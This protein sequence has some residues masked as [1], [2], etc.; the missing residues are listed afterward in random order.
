MKLAA[1]IPIDRRVARSEGRELAER[2]DGAVLFADLAGFTP[3]SEALAKR[4]G[5]LRGAEILSA[6]LNGLLDR[7]IAAV[8]DHH[9]S[10]VS[11]NGDAIT[12][13]FAAPYD[14]HALGCALAM[15]RDLE[16]QFESPPEL[17]APDLGLKTAV[18]AGPVRRFV[19]GDPAIQRMD[20][21]TG[22]LLDRMR[23]AEQLA[24]AG[25]VIVD[26]EHVARLGN[27]LRISAWREAD[28][29][30]FAVVD[31][32]DALPAPESWGP[33]EGSGV[34][35]RWDSWI[36]SQVR[37]RLLTGDARLFAEFRSPVVFFVRFDGIRYETDPDAG[38]QLDAFVRW[39]QGI[40]HAYEGMVLQL[41]VGD[42]GSYLYGAFGALLAHEDDN[43]RAATAAS[44]LAHPPAELGFVRD[45]GV[46][47]N[48][49]QVYAGA[50]G[51]DRRFTY[52]LLGREV[53]L[54][55]RFMQLA[56]ASEV[57]AT[58]PVHR[59]LARQFVFRARGEQAIKGFST[60]IPVHQLLERREEYEPVAS[61]MELTPLVGR[62][63]TLDV[64]AEG[65]DALQRGESRRVLVV[66]DAG[67]GKSRLAAELRRMAAG[68][69]MAAAFGQAEAIERATPYSAWPG[70]LRK[71]L[72]VQKGWSPEQVIAH[73]AEL[74][75]DT[76][77]D[78]LPLAGAALGIHLGDTDFT[79]QLEGRVRADN[80]RA[81]VV[82][83]V[84]AT[85]ERHGGGLLLAIEDL[86]WSNASSWALLALLARKVRPLLLVLT[87]RPVE[88]PPS[89]LDEL[90]DD[91]EATTIRLQALDQE[92]IAALVR[93]RLGV[94]NLPDE[95]AEF[96]AARGHGNPLFCEELALACLE[97]GLLEVDGG[98][99]RVPPGGMDRAAT[100]AGGSARSVV[101]A[102]IDRLPARQQAAL[103]A[104]SV[105]GSRFD[106]TALEA[107]ME[108]GRGGILGLLD[109]AEA[110]GILQRS[111]DDPERFAFHNVLFRDVVYESLLFAQRTELHEQAATWIEG[112]PGSDLRLLGPL[113]AHHWERAGNVPR[114]LDYLEDSGREALRESAS[115]ETVFLLGRALKLA[116]GEAD[117][118]AERLASWELLL[119][120]A[121][122]NLL[123]YKEGE[124]H[125]ERGLA[126]T[127][128][129]KPRSTTS[130]L[131]RIGLESAR[132]LVHR[133]WPRR[134][135][136]RLSGRRDALL[137]AARAYER[138]TE[139]Y[140]ITGRELPGFY[141]VFRQLNLSE[142]A[143]SSPELSRGYA[144]IGAGLGFVA[145][146]RMARFYF[147][148]AY[149][150]L[151][152]LDD[153]PSRCFSDILKGLYLVGVGRWEASRELLERA[154][155]IAQQ[156][157][158][159]RRLSDA[160]S[161]MAPLHLFT[162]RLADGEALGRELY[163]LNR[164]S[165][166]IR[167]RYEALYLHSLFLQEL[168]RDDEIAD[169]LER[170]QS[171]FGEHSSVLDIFLDLGIHALSSTH[172]VRSGRLDEGLRH[173]LKALEVGRRY[174]P[175]IVSSMPSFA[176]PGEVLL[177]LWERG[178]P[179][180][181]D[182]RRACAFM[183]RFAKVFPVGRPR[184]ALLRG[185]LARLSGRPGRARRT[186][187]RSLDTARQLE[188]PL[189]EGL[190]ELELARL[191]DGAERRDRRVRAEELLTRIGATRA[192][193][194][195]RLDK[196]DA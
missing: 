24:R 12:C 36:Q 166:Y 118:L 92:D 23:S 61:S 100:L 131:A 16:G 165:D 30:R 148:Q 184:A 35:R 74:A 116:G 138:L 42:K 60:P 195:L 143:G 176:A 57:L 31:S 66:G 125:I 142:A 29:Q 11:F 47:L 119:G 115:E 109:G 108:L 71:L 130:M 156:L 39:V 18:C 64:L 128:F 38:R 75:D 81:L 139:L 174:T 53:N 58:P 1:Y 98:I 48:R 182:A 121:Y 65:L 84:A 185:R 80:I 127:G 122:V 172:A 114:A 67:L 177:E 154:V 191:S 164:R 158:D 82:H 69:P 168:A 87:S 144:S 78:A 147:A 175:N 43:R 111:A 136:G 104:A 79:R 187:Q 179:H 83:L 149:A 123:R 6:R 14:E 68:R 21:L 153:L 193:A 5:P 155:S 113:L 183:D 40:V 161:I 169:N 25:E 106:V 26:T 15:H 180:P 140:L 112:K 59:T 181:A 105:L 85:L 141:S 194:R 17:G 101:M 170:L 145:L 46:G 49:G 120:E 19:A 62:D 117:V 28:G 129:P 55:A 126:L 2:V 102:R 189:D 88:P 7:M 4:L 152:R 44:R 33:T 99:C 91:P 132:Q 157:G 54:A 94:G 50:Y 34:D 56:G 146:H 52:G 8:H 160:W 162:G 167:N 151:E 188:M 86:H 163:R 135:V 13:W 150:V 73:L 190:A 63:S 134:F 93:F 90:F 22:S 96:I 41:V 70:V 196:G 97:T 133:L 9:G 37:D 178:A 89:E 45:V 124:E 20:A 137:T 51:S 27:R 32:F 77:F 76:L 110:A 103:K 192:L 173:A 171:L 159:R 107:V 95:L 10:V 72:G 186:L 3:Y